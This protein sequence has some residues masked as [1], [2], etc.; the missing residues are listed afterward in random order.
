MLLH[1]ENYGELK[2]FFFC[3]MKF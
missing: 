2:I 1:D 3:F